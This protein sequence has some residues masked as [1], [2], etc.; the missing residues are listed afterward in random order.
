MP[1]PHFEGKTTVQPLLYSSFSRDRQLIYS[2]SAAFRRAIP[3]PAAD[4]G[5]GQS[6]PVP[7]SSPFSAPSALPG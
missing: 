6:R 5:P 4:T 7:S 2:L 1:S 3:P